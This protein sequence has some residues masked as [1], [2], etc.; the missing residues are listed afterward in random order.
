MT[1]S[2]EDYEWECL[3]ER[4]ERNKAWDEKRM[5]TIGSNGN[6]GEHYAK[7]TPCQKLGYKVGDR[8]KVLKDYKHSEAGDEGLTVELLHDDGSDM[9][10]FFFVGETEWI[11]LEDLQK[12][13]NTKPTRWQALG[14]NFGDQ[15]EVI[16]EVRTGSGA[17]EVGEIVTLCD[18]L[19]MDMTRFKY[20]DSNIGAI[21]INPKQLKKI[22]SK[23]KEQTDMNDPVE[24]ADEQFNY[25]PVN[26]P[27]HYN[28]G[29]IECIDAIK[30]SM[31]A[32]EFAGYLKGNAMKYLWRYKDKGNPAQDLAKCAWYLRRL[33]DEV[34]MQ[35]VEK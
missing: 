28:Q 35:E 1:Q 22:E 14:Y 30:A 23:P 32:E 19:G 31:S 16:E 2:D 10:Q 13:E 9:P 27:S 21:Y 26:Q 34:A 3:Q 20:R 29:G 4:I 33:Q 5:D 18:D 25:D 17:I 11:R 12:I 24:D 7:L 8:F 15:F 6:T